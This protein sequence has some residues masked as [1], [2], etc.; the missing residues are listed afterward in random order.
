MI[1]FN[2]LTLLTMVDRVFIQT[3]VHWFLPS[4][5]LKCWD[6][7]RKIF[8]ANLHVITTQSLPMTEAGVADTEIYK[9]YRHRCY[10]SIYLKENCSKDWGRFLIFVLSSTLSS[11]L[12]QRAWVT[13]L[14]FKFDSLLYLIQSM[15]KIV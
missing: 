5:Q 3:V 7:W 14:F 12:G 4:T 8:I 15:M 1:I 11:K 9:C 6:L 13:I 10:V 2:F